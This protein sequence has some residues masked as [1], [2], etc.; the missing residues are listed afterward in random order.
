[1]ELHRLEPALSVWGSHHRDVDLD[2]VEPGDTGSS[3]SLDYRPTLQLQTNFD[4]ECGNGVE[5]VDNDAV[6]SIRWIVIVLLLGWTQ[7]LMAASNL[8]MNRHTMSPTPDWSQRTSR[9]E[10]L[11][12][13][14][15]SLRSD[16][17][18]PIRR[19]WSWKSRS[20]PPPCGQA[21]CTRL[22]LT[23]V[24]RCRNRPSGRLRAGEL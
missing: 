10:G 16:S 2:I 20:T 11:M 7:P 3:A 1:V 17:G 19:M 22:R 5:V 12:A 9:Y 14:S 8:V 15:H 4:K 23:K 13:G 18:S 24:R 21:S 6:F